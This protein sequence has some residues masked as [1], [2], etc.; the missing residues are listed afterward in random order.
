MLFTFLRELYP[1]QQEGLARC[2]SWQRENERGGLC[3]LVT[4][5]H[6]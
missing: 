2:W 3:N 1:A 5:F 6:N 4:H